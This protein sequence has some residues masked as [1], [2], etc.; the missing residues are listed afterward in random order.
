MIMKFLLLIV[1]VFERYQQVLTRKFDDLD[2]NGE[3]EVLD[4]LST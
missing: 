3:N 4:S 1:F 2:E